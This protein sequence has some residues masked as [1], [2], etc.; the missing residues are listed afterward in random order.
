MPLDD[1]IGTLNG[2]AG[3]GGCVMD[4]K[5]LIY[6]AA[7][8]DCGSFTK[9][10]AQLRVAQPALSRQI[11]LLEEEF[12]LEL[13]VRFDRQTKMTDAGEVLLKHARQLIRGFESVG[14]EMQLLGR[15]PRGSVIVGA[16]PSLGTVIVPKIVERLR[17]EFADVALKVREGT[18]PFLEHSI[19]D[20]QVDLALIAEEPGV[21]AIE[22]ETLAHEDIVLISRKELLRRIDEQSGWP[23]EDIA[24]MFSQQVNALVTP[25]L[26]EAGVVL[27][28]ALEIDALHAIKAMTLQ[29]RGVALMPIGVFHEELEA[30]LLCAAR[31]CRVRLSRPIVLVY[32]A[33]RTLSPAVEATARILREEVQ[34][35]ARARVF[36]LTKSLENR[37]VPLAPVKAEMN[38]ARSARRARAPA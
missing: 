27:P 1:T 13:L 29:G 26:E 14:N 9:A 22:S 19:I 33:V 25:I 34:A 12:G 31:I 20:A 4:F 16:P 35:L 28:S 36:T 6:F 17:D 5:K 23:P 24:V 32:S 15:R 2:A 7:V 3:S 21:R 30:G 37:A 11:R 8:A 10:A 38:P 18:A